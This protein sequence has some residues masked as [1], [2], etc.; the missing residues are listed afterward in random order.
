MLFCSATLFVYVSKY[1]LYWR[2]STQPTPTLVYPK[3]NYTY[4]SLFHFRSRNC[5]GSAM[6]VILLAQS[7]HCD[8]LFNTISGALL[9][10]CTK[11]IKLDVFTNR[12]TVNCGLIKILFIYRICVIQLAEISLK[13]SFNVVYWSQD[14]YKT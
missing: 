8:L 14:N 13:E 1:F 10:P 3:K 2:M 9:L 4:F 11:Y 12:N 5:S 7:L 6:F